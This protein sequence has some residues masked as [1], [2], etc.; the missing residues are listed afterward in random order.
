VAVATTPPMLFLFVL[1]TMADLMLMML[2]GVLCAL[3]SMVLVQAYRLAPVA[4]V[5]PFQYTQMPYAVVAGM[6]LFGDQAQPTIIAGAAIVAASG[7][8]MLLAE[9]YRFEGHRRSYRPLAQTSQ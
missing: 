2:G 5:A 8:F 1:P 6:V 4:V 7:V 3:G 9:T